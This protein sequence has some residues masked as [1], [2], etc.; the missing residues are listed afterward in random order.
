[1]LGV[2]LNYWN[3]KKADSGIV[4]A[5]LLRTRDVRNS[6]SVH[7]RAFSTSVSVSVEKVTESREFYHKREDPH[8]ARIFK[9]VCFATIQNLTF[10]LNFR[11]RILSKSL[12]YFYKVSFFA[13][14]FLKAN[15]F[16]A[17][18]SC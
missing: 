2:F 15:N 13:P 9:K 4:E 1:M 12:I 8:F 11:V 17:I 10:F 6:V 18:K 3:R 16:K 5:N 14:E 7:F